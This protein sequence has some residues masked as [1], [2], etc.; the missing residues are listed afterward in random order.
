MPAYGCGKKITVYIPTKYSHKEIEV[1]CGSTAYNGGINQ[2]DDC[3]SRTGP[4]PLPYED[5]GDM[6][7]DDRIHRGDE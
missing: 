1:D 6:E 5:E 2:C 3:A 4:I 7:W